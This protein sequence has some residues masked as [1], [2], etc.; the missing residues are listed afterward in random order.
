M[1]SDPTRY[2]LQTITNNKIL[3]NS[4]SF[5]KDIQCWWHSAQGRLS[6]ALFQGDKSSLIRSVSFCRQQRTNR[7]SSC[8]KRLAVYSFARVSKPTFLRGPMTG[9]RSRYVRSVRTANQVPSFLFSHTT[10]LCLQAR[11]KGGNF[12]IILPLL[13]RV[14]L[15][16]SSHAFRFLPCN[17]KCRRLLLYDVSFL[18]LDGKLL[19]IVFYGFPR[20]C[21][22]FF[23]TILYLRHFPGSAQVW[24]ASLR[25]LYLLT[26]E[27]FCYI[28]AMV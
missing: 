20:L 28:S 7:C 26:Y 13:L 11:K 27:M 23:K 25:S 16:S 5:R 21:P 3:V 12:V 18:P 4:S 2:S 24:C 14:P 9:Y 15:P 1:G 19:I 6:A 22:T 17:D 8:W 10:R